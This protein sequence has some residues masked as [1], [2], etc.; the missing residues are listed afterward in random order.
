MSASKTADLQL[1][2]ALSMRS[3]DQVRNRF[4]E[5]IRKCTNAFRDQFAENAENFDLRLNFG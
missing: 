4:I 5:F 2:I 3:M 1:S